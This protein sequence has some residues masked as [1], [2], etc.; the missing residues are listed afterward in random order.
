LADLVLELN[1]PSALVR[2]RDAIARALRDPSLELGFWLPDERRYVDSD[3]RPVQL[4]TEDDDHAV[5]FLDSDGSQLAAL[6]FDP[7]LL[8]D[9][10]MVNAVASAA[11]LALENARL[12]AEL[13]ARM[14]EL[15]ASRVRIVEAGDAERRTIERNLH[16][17]AQQRLLGI[18]LALRSAHARRNDADAVAALIT[19]ADMEVVVA[20]DELRRLARGIHP[21][22]LAE[23]GL[24]AALRELAHRSTVPVTVTV[25]TGRLPA[26]IEAAAYFVAA[27]ALSNVV[28]HAQAQSA[29][30]DVG[31][32]GTQLVVEIVD[33][34]VGGADA[35]RG[36]G[37]QNLRDRVE[38]LSGTLSITSERSGT[39]VRAVIPCE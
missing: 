30:M 34:G 28:K 13:Q 1:E 5:E 6:V 24:E 14:V 16:D 21:A 11:R 37:L 9:R 20:I 15:R 26:P 22:L 8:E 36:S 35:R 19:E 23:A 31:S 29:R 25:A 4:P 18:R 7:S 33:D 39:R 32:D 12:V 10:T 38:A 27:E 3:G 2:P 17:G